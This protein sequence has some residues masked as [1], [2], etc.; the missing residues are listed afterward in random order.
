LRCACASCAD[1]GFDERHRHDLG[2]AGQVDRPDFSAGHRRK[3]AR[4]STFQANFRCLKT[5]VYFHDQILV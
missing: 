1:I 5:G 2:K 3:A 4:S